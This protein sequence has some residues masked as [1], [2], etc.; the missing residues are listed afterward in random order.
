MYG[1][2]VSLPPATRQ[3]RRAG[4]TPAIVGALTDL[5]LAAGLGAIRATHG[6]IG[7]RHVEGP[8]PTLAIVIALAAPG[9]V[10]LIGVVIDRPVLF[11]AAGIAC[12]PLVIVSIAAVPIWLAGALFM[13]AFVRATST[14]RSLSLLGGLVL[15]GFQVPILVGLW[16]L[17]TET[18]EFTYNFPGGS[19]GGEY[20]TP[21]HAVICIVIVMLDLF[22]VTVLA[23]L[24]PPPGA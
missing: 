21:G 6:S 10:A 20:F 17:I 5:A 2:L 14:Q 13:I 1:R 15:V 16:I 9:I 11:G 22:V 19:E 8:L 3:R 4:T 24:N 7:E 18:R 23:R 12:L